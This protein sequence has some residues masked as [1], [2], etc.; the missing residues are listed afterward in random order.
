MVQQ[1]DWQRFAT[2]LVIVIALLAVAGAFW[3]FRPYQFEQSETHVVLYS[4]EAQIPLLLDRLSANDSF[5]VAVELREQ[6]P[7]NQYMANALNL[8]SVVLI[9]NQ[10]AVTNVFLVNS[11]E[12]ELL[13]CHTNQ[14]DVLTDLELSR[15]DCLALL[16]SFSGGKI[17]IRLPQASV[18]K[19]QA[20][21][22]GNQLELRAS[23]VEDLSFAS[24]AVLERLFE[25][26]SAIL[27]RVNNAAGAAQ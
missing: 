17:V 2:V 14:G 24:L 7:T 10:K 25:N 11:P 1:N 6:G 5:L 12:N 27:A 13:S 8:F 3:F 16:D 4:N 23:K 19:A 20:V 15:D 22:S 26:T 18:G 9:G 21:L